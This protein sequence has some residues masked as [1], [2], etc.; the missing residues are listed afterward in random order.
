MID[1]LFN[2]TFC[3]SPGHIRLGVYN[4]NQSLLTHLPTYEL[5]IQ[6]LFS[7]IAESES[8]LLQQ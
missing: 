6:S 4:I 3:G 1:P 7:G 2:S 5:I 8:S